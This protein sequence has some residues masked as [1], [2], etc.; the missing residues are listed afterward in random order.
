MQAPLV[1]GGDPDYLSV[2]DFKSCLSSENE[3]S[4][5]KYCLPR[6]RLSACPKDSYDQLKREDEVMPCSPSVDVKQVQGYKDCVVYTDDNQFC[7][8][9]ANKGNNNCSDDAY[10]SISDIKLSPCNPAQA[11]QVNVTAQIAKARQR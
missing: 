10:K 6:G 11:Q 1:Y 3:G 4:W 5:T 2:K 9:T 7:L 8:N